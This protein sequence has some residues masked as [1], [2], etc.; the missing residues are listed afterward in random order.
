V[1][2][3]RLRAV[4]VLF[5]MLAAAVAA[6]VLTPHTH[7]SDRLGRLNLQADVPRQLGPWQLDTSEP[8]YV[9]NP[10]VAEVLNKIYSQTLTRT[11][12]HPKGYRIMLSI[13][14]GGD[15]RDA[16]QVHYPEV[17]YPAQGFS[18]LQN[19]IDRIT[20]AQNQIA[21]RRLQTVLGSQRKEPVTYWTTVGEHVVQGDVDKKLTEMSYGLQGLIPDGLLFRVSSLDADTARAFE[22]QDQ[23][24]RDAV[25][26]LPASVRARL[27]GIGAAAA[28]SP[29]KPPQRSSP[30]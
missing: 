16:M 5:F 27:T 10:Q 14:Y 23:F 6:A 8:A 3:P 17:C 19:H 9:V 18:V 25:Q 4:I 26:A 24:V 28:T 11:Y 7:L 2:K 29:P 12:V 13:A 21:V 1:I 30:T 15:Q 22:W 20:V